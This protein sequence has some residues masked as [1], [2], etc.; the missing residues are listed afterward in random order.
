MN[1]GKVTGNALKRSVLKP[2][3]NRRDEVICGAGVGAD[4]AI[5]AVPE[6]NFAASCVQEAAVAGKADMGRLIGRCANSLAAAGGSP[7]AA[8]ISLAL[9]ESA[10][11]SQLKELM[12]AAEAA[13]KQLNM[14]IVGGHTTVSRAVNCAFATVT[15]YGAVPTDR[16]KAEVTQ[17]AAPGQDVVISKWIG[18]EGTALLAAKYKDSLLT[19]Y[20][21]YLV[22]EAEGFLRYLSVIPEAAVAVKS[23]VCAM[24]DA[25][26]GGILAALWEL[27]ERSG[28]GLT[29]DLKKLP[30]RQETVEI[31]EHTGANPYILL[32]G[33]SLIMTTEDG[34]GLVQALKDAHIPA[35]IVGKITDS[36]DRLI[37][38]DEEVRYMDRPAVDDIY[39]RMD[40]E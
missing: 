9:P 29:I 7:I 35:V 19:R 25:S 13:C 26:E 17:K 33:G 22:E 23:G 37:L 12:V 6:R 34:Q 10:E 14:Q 18:L 40:Q 32:S 27:A 28:V 4:C 30:I 24:H 20:P 39:L 15:V 31:C 1:I 11:E 8:M 36:K 38:N 3:E 21:A 16:K 5:F 2:I